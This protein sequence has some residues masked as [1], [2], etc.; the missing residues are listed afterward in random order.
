MFPP[1]TARMLK[2]LISRFKDR[3]SAPAGM[4]AR[5]SVCEN[6]S[7][8]A[9]FHL[10]DSSEP[11]PRWPERGA[12]MIAATPESLLATQVVTIDKIRASSPLLPT[13]FT[14]LIVPVLHRYAAWVHLLPASESHHHYGPGGLLAHGLEVAMHAAR[15]ADGKA[16]GIELPPSDRARYAPRWKVASMLAGLLHDLGKP[17]VDVGATDLD[18][19]MTWPAQAGPIYSWLQEHGLTHYQFYWR[20]GSRHERHKPVGTAVSREVIGPEL[21]RWLSDEPTQAVVDLMM[22]SIA[23]GKTR[24]NLMSVIVSDA[25]SMSVEA[26][27]RKL[28]EKSRATGQGALNSAASLVIAEIRSAV[29]DGTIPINKNGRPLW[30]T[31]EGLVGMYP[32]ILDE[33]IPR[34]A[35]KKIQ[36]IPSSR[37]ELAKLLCETGFAEPATGTDEDG[38]EHQSHTWEMTMT[39][40]HGDIQITPPALRVLK[41]AKPEFVLGALPLPPPHEALVKSPLLGNKEKDA[42][43]MGIK[44]LAEDGA[45]LPPPA[46]GQPAPQGAANQAPAADSPPAADPAQDAAAP[47]EGPVIES[48]RNRRD[49]A[50][51]RSVEQQRRRES[52]EDARAL[53]DQ[54]SDLLEKIRKV[55]MEGEVVATVLERIQAGALLFGEDFCDTVDGLA[56]RFPSGLER[57]GLPPADILAPLAA[58]NWLSV[59]AGSDRKVCDIDYP[60]GQRH[61]SIVFASLVGRAWSALKAEHEEVLTARPQLRKAPQSATAAENP[62]PPARDKPTQP[63]QRTQPRANPAQ[64]ERKPAAPPPQASGAATPPVQGKPQ[65][66]PPPPAPAPAQTDSGGRPRNKADITATKASDLTPKRVRFINEAA[67]SMLHREKLWGACTGERLHAALVEFAKR[68][69]IRLGLLPTALY[70]AEHGLLQGP[71]P[72]KAFVELGSVTI[73]SAYQVPEWITALMARSS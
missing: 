72:D 37:P 4:P 66:T 39:V 5:D 9:P 3:T 27:L 43:A 22:L 42:L 52:R 10:G 51:D 57:T 73:R 36:G 25:D 30:W 56:V 54:Y 20:P 63:A 8:G 46:A 67:C 71:A 61:K 26:D 17:L 16:V 18:R 40:G 47:D 49:L 41:F 24:G 12:A 32:A 19:T 59:E 64:P 35:A 48:R 69:D 45:G 60:T 1:D 21:L 28:A 11:V 13:E 14:Q 2:S 55:G 68:N 6:V 29:D 65:T 58:R 38:E 23:Q 62:P 44:V 15:M 53:N 34:L 50:N 33:V 7:P 31:S 70:D